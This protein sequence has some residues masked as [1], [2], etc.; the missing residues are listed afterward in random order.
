VARGI[1]LADVCLGLDDPSAA[2]YAADGG[3]EYGAQQMAGDQFRV[4]VIESRRKR[5]H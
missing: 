1:V 4:P 2:P 5:L 3:L